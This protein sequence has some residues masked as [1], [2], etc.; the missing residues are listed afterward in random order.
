[1]TQMPPAAADA[2]QPRRALSLLDSTSIIVGIII[3][4]AS[5]KARPTSRPVR[6][7]WGIWLAGNWR[8]GIGRLRI[9]DW[10]GC[11]HRRVAVRRTD[12]AGRRDVLRGA[13]DGL[14]AEPAARMSFCRKPS[15]ATSALRLPGPSSGSCG[16]AT[17]ARS[18]SSWPAMPARSA[19]GKLRRAHRLGVAAWRRGASWSCRCSTPLGLRAGKWTQNV[20][21]ACKVAGAGGDR[22][23]GVYA[24]AGRRGQPLPA[25]GWQTLGAGA[26]PRDVRLWRLGR[27]VVR[28]GRSAR[29]GA[30][31]LRGRCCWARWPSRSS[32]C[33]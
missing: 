15:A 22:R 14:S 20:L 21:T 24:A 31:Y 11:D 2:N 12:R 17:S 28:R 4:S 26:D 25:D 13:G 3:G 18:R 5:I 23:D 1:M 7:R 19:A 29:S 30:E 16:R 8:A 27:H 6:R 32:T 9:G 10:N 33:R